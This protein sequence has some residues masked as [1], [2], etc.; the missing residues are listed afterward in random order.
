MEQDARD[1]EYVK[2]ILDWVK[3]DARQVYIRVTGALGIATLFV[4]QIK[5]AELQTLERWPMRALFAGLASLAAAALAYFFYVSRTHVARRA[6]AKYLHEGNSADAEKD[7]I[8]IFREWG[9]ILLIGNV[10]FG[11][12]VLLLGYVLGELIV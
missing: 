11:V 4:T 5:I 2:A 9:L 7:A 12:G 8:G 10:L 3:D 1:L 6:I